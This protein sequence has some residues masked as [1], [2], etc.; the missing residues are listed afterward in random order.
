MISASPSFRVLLLLHTRLHVGRPE[1][2]PVRQH[3]TGHPTMTPVLPACMRIP[4][5]Q[6]QTLPF[7]SPTVQT[8]PQFYRLKWPQRK[9]SRLQYKCHST[10][11]NTS[12]YAKF[13]SL[14]TRLHTAKGTR[15][16]GTASPPHIR[17]PTCGQY[18]YGKLFTGL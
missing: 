6:S 8:L 15:N 18:R 11:D 12:F 3:K 5:I 17:K 7:P 16:Q 9:C 10:P 2:Q 14:T 1:D 4:Q 13:I